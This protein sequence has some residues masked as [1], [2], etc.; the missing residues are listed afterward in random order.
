MFSDIC[1][2]APGTICCCLQGY[3]PRLCHRLGHK[4]NEIARYYA[5]CIPFSRARTWHQNQPPVR[6]SAKFLYFPAFSHALPFVTLE[7][8]IFN[9]SRNLPDF[10]T[11]FEHQKSSK[12][13]SL[14]C[15]STLY[16]KTLLKNINDFRWLSFLETTCHILQDHNLCNKTAYLSDLRTIRRQRQAINNN[17]FRQLFLLRT[18]FQTLAWACQATTWPGSAQKRH[19]WRHGHGGSACTWLLEKG[20]GIGLY[21]P[22]K[23]SEIIVNFHFC[24]HNGGLRVYPQLS[25]SL[26]NNSANLTE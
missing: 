26:S 21:Y 2:K 20:W 10:E 12:N 16:F 7:T 8:Y 13:S 9:D 5:I 15:L 6:I 24:A 3:L 23:H 18:L 17:Y 22:F 4:N 14:S 19:I 25:F 11:F 1:S